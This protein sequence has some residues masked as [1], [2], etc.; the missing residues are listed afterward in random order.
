[1][2]VSA[3]RVASDDVQV[4]EELAQ[5][6]G[7]AHRNL[8][9][10]IGILAAILSMVMQSLMNS[11]SWLLAISMMMALSPLAYEALWH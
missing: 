3:A 5:H 8:A 9:V 2:I 11:H 1:M 6:G 10:M 4:D 7:E